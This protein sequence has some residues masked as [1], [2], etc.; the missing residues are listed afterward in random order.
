M[1]E[2]FVKIGEVLATEIDEIA[3]VTYVDKDLGYVM[4]LRLNDGKKLILS[5]MDS[6]L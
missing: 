3:D 5:L 2:L 6:Q 4:Y 1:E